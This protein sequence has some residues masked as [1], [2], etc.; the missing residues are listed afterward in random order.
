M[1]RQFLTEFNFVREG[2]ALETIGT[3]VNA[4]FGPD[5]HVPRPYRQLCSRRVCVMERLDNHV[6]LGTGG[7]FGWF[8]FGVLCVLCVHSSFFMTC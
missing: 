8:S 2:W 6:K 3:P 5:V 1:E 7:M 4:T